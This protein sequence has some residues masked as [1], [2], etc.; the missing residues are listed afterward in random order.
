MG[1]IACS[2]IFIPC[3]FLDIIFIWAHTL[4]VEV[5]L[6]T[7]AQ[8]FLLAEDGY[9]IETD[10]TDEESILLAEGIKEYEK[11]PASFITIK[12]CKKSRSIA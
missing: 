11:S 9:V 4:V 10:L 8:K 6:G 2:L 1:A 7:K 5:R 12:E 3:A